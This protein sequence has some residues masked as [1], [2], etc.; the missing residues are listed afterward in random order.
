MEG[1]KDR[2]QASMNGGSRGR[3]IANFRSAEQHEAQKERVTGLCR[4]GRKMGGRRSLCGKMP[5]LAHMPGTRL[6]MPSPTEWHLKSA[7]EQRHMALG[8]CGDRQKAEED[9]IAALHLPMVQAT[10]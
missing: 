2:V 4:L 5:P 3:R 8:V 10:K 9:R 6:L 1:T 7:W